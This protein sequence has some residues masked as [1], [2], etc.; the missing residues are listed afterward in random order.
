MVWKIETIRNH[1]KNHLETVSLI[2]NVCFFFYFECCCTVL[3]A[4]LS[5][6]KNLSVNHWKGPLSSYYLE[7]LSRKPVLT[8]FYKSILFTEYVLVLFKLRNQSKNNTD[9]SH[10]S[11]P[12]VGWRFSWCVWSSPRPC[13]D[14]RHKTSPW[15]SAG[16]HSQNTWW[17]ETH[18]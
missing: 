5:E 9:F 17:R 12:L 7:V 14:P 2:L 1:G 4:P 16:A 15:I 8:A 10:H 18:P 3:L 11:L 6:Y 13:P